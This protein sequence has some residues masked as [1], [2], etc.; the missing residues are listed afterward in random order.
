MARHNDVGSWGENVAA[1]YL[2]GRGYAI[3]GRNVRI[4]HSEIDIIAVKG[5]DIAFVEVKTRSTAA[6]DPLEAVS[7]DKMR[8]LARAADRYIKSTGCRHRPRF[9]I[10]TVVGSRDS[11]RIEHFEDAFLPPLLTVG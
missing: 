6:V 10:I 2:T 7:P 1:G 11:F 8:R 4:G 5:G 3:A 9:D